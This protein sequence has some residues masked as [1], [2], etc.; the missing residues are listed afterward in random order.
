MLPLNM[1]SIFDR[2]LRKEL[3]LENAKI[4]LQKA[5]I[6]R[7]LEATTWRIKNAAILL[8]I[9]RTTLQMMI[10]R[11]GIRE[12]KKDEMMKQ[13]E[14]QI[15]EDIPLFPKGTR[16]LITDL[17][18]GKKHSHQDA[19]NIA[20]NYG[21]AI[22]VIEHISLWQN[23]EEYRGLSGSTFWTGSKN[24]GSFYDD[25]AWFI[26]SIDGRIF[27]RDEDNSYDGIRCLMII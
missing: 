16:L 18:Y 8:G 19:I 10:K 21:R 27:N 13:A 25:N 14:I 12:V 24:P 2:C 20:K 23:S 7:A 11:F 15:L 26:S 9:H 3:S 5:L 17:P 1:N 22:D 6:L 4:A